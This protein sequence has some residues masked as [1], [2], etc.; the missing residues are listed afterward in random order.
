LVAG[1]SIVQEIAG[2]EQTMLEMEID[3]MAGVFDHF[4]WIRVPAIA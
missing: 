2:P 3:P 4:G 1:I